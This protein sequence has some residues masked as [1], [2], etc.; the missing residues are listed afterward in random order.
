MKPKWLSQSLL[1]W[2]T[3]VRDN[4]PCRIVFLLTLPKFVIVY[5][6]M[7]SE[8]H[9]PTLTLTSILSVGRG[10][11]QQQDP[12]WCTFV[13]CCV[14]AGQHHQHLVLGFIGLNCCLCFDTYINTR[15]IFRESFGESYLGP[16]STQTLVFIA[17]S[18]GGG[19][20]SLVCDQQISMTRAPAALL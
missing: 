18:A 2:E 8:A 13:L 19:T 6:P 12:T 16:I 1:W 14:A 20:G 3:A 5:N 9:I 10:I 7:F 15:I 17:Q 4:E 11:S